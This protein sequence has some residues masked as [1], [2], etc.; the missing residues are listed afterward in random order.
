[1]NFYDIKKWLNYRY[2]TDKYSKRLY[3]VEDIYVHIISKLKEMEYEVDNKDNF[4]LDL[5]NYILKYSFLDKS[6]NIEIKLKKD[7]NEN[8]ND[9]FIDDLY[10]DLENYIYGNNIQILNKNSNNKINDFYNL[11]INNFLI[12]NYNNIEDEENSDNDFIYVD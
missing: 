2:S 9:L 7:Y 10:S 5:L 12:P 4:Y 6:F 1:M 11:I 3:I 8:I